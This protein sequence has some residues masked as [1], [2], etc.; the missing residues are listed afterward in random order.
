MNKR[1]RIIVLID[2]SEY[3]ENLINFAFSFS[4]CINAKVIFVHQILGMTPAFSDQE[5]RDEIIRKETAEASAKLRKLAK[6]RIY[7]DDSFNVSQ[8]HVLTTLSELKADLYTDWV[9]VGLK[10]TGLLK[11]LLIGSTTLSIIDESDLLTVAVPV[12]MPI[13]VPKKLIVGVTHQF[14]LNKHQF[15]I[16]LSNLDGQITE[17][18]F[19]TILQDGEDEEEARQHLTSLQREYAAY[20]SRI[21]LSKGEDEFDALKNYVE[22]AEHPFLVLQQGSRSLMDEIF[23]KYMINEL[24]YSGQI[25]LIILSK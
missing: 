7:G 22:Q 1:N 20:N 21:F 15:N 18:K 19:F 17:V 13:L 12:R 2:L 10:K 23:R 24:V 6:G 8:K 9:F 16:V 3:S 5:S 14:P 4:E 11:R 25:P